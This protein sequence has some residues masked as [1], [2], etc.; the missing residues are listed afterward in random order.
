MLPSRSRLQGWAPE[1]LFSSASAIRDAG[2]SIYEAVLGLDDRI[3]RMP[4]ARGWAGEAH[5]AAA[6]MFGR[7][8]A[9]ASVVKNYAEAFADALEGGS[10]AIG[11]ARTALLGTADEIDS[12]PLHVTDQWVVMIDPAAMSAQQSAELQKQAQ[13]AQATINDLLLAVG[14]ADDRTARQL[15]LARI[16]G[17]VF[18]NLEYGPPGPIPALPGDDVFSPSTE[19]GKQFQEIARAQDLATTVREVTETVDDHGNRLT[20]YTMLDGSEQVAT[21]YVGQGSPS[22]QLYPVGTVTVSHTDK[23]GKAVSL[24]STIP[25]EEGG[26]LTEVWYANGTHVAISETAEGVL[27]GSC[28]TPDGR[29]GILPDSFFNDPVP[30]LAGGM[31]SGLEKL[32]AKGIPVLSADVLDGLRAGGKFGGPAVGVAS[33]IYNMVSAETLHDR[34][35]AA[36]SGGVGLV[37]GLAT[38]VGVG[39]IPGVGPAAAMGISTPAGFIWGYVGELV[40]NI[41]CPP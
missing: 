24:T 28:T 37:G 22:E 17:E 33:M 2:K 39:A 10:A 19:E 40:G 38:S 14:E 11:Q 7:A 15:L 13:T 16:E 3:D 32:P 27:T 18:E 1:S 23:N 9:R 41:V 29:T 5:D 8:T 31:L 26:K 20:T 30:T 36:W 12:G 4:E 6:D 25:R 21:E 34:C 35:V